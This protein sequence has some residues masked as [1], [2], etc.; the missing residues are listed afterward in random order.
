MIVTRISFRDNFVS[1]YKGAVA[2]DRRFR[3]VTPRPVHDCR[4][5]KALDFDAKPVTQISISSFCLS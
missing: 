1:N 3:I 2:L 4:V 5:Y